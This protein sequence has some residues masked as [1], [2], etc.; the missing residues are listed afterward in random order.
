[1]QSLNFICS[2]GAFKRQWPGTF[3]SHFSPTIAALLEQATTGVLGMLELIY[4]AWAIYVY[5]VCVNFFQ[6]GWPVLCA[7]IIKHVFPA[8][9]MME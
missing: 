6:R 8:Y 1:M 4:I 3:L 5:F 7:K 2:K 9:H